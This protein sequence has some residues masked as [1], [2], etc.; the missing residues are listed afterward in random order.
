MPRI[1]LPLWQ[2]LRF[3][4]FTATT[5]LLV[6]VPSPLVSAECEVWDRNQKVVSLKKLPRGV[7]YNVQKDELTCNLWSSCEGWT[8]H[9]CNK[10]VCSTNH[11]CLNTVF[12]FNEQVKCQATNACHRAS[13]YESHDVVCGD[14]PHACV[15]TVVETD[16]LLH[17]HGSHSCTLPG[18]PPPLEL[19]Q[20]LTPEQ[21]LEAERNRDIGDGSPMISVG[22]SGSVLC[23][24]DTGDGVACQSMYIRVPD[25]KR[26]CQ[27]HTT[28]QNSPCA[29]VCLAPESCDL[30]TIIFLVSNK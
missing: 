1:S 24:H 27:T 22:K 25:N 29:L 15:D 28:L 18:G 3:V 6:L 5:T 20:E 21:V 8:I 16:T 19:S 26:A 10:V 12:R 13:F 2:R 7:W 30:S 4:L 11:A 23:A 17:C 14:P 9:N